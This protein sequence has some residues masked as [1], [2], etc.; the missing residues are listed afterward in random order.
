MYN[1]FSPLIFEVLLLFAGTDSEARLQARCGKV[2]LA[3]A[4]SLNDLSCIAWL[5][6]KFPSQVN[7]VYSCCGTPLMSAALFGHSKSVQ[8]LLSLGADVKK[9]DSQKRTVLHYAVQSKNYEIVKTLL[10]KGA[11]INAQDENG[12]SPLHSAAYY[13]ALEIAKLLIK[14]GGN[15]QLKHRIYDVPLLH[16][17]EFGNVEVA[18]LFLPITKLNMLKIQGV[19]VMFLAA[20]ASNI[21]LLPALIKRGGNIN[22]TGDDGQTPLHSSVRFADAKTVKTLLKYGADPNFKDKNGDT[23]LHDACFYRKAPIVSVLIGGGAKINAVNKKGQTPLHTA[24]YAGTTVSIHMYGSRKLGIRPGIRYKKIPPEVVEL[25]IK[26]GAK[27]NHI[28]LEGNTPLHI[29]IKRNECKIVELLIK[30]GAK[31]NI[32]NLKKLLK[33]SKCKTK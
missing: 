6:K 14:K 12:A 3:R 32:K 16:A 19:K 33:T 29:A 30:N 4:A 15:V 24:V 8:L 5:G 21:S 31:T 20:N 27:L 11:D 13:N 9:Q 18:R 10:D 7:T 25:L 26:K 17:M 22:I 2:N 23:P 28:D 1:F